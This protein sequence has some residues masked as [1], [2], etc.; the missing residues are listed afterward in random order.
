MLTAT[1]IVL[2]VL[3]LLLAVYLICLAPC[4]KRG[5]RFRPFEEVYIAHRGFFDNKG[6]APENSLAAFAAATERGYGIE[7]DVQ[8][9]RDGYLVVFHDGNLKRMCG[10]DREVEEC[11]YEELCQYT[12]ASSQKKIPLFSEA[13]AVIGG[14]VPLIVEIKN[15]PKWREA[16]EETAKLLDT[17]TGIYCLESFGPRIVAWYRKNRP[18][19]I[20]G[21]L[22]TNYFKDEPEMRF[23]HKLWLTNLLY[24]VKAKPD[25]I[26]YHHIHKNQF[27]YRLL[28]K[29]FRVKNVAWTIKNQ[30]QLEAAKDVFT[31]IIF[32]SFTPDEQ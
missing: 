3:V 1:I 11:T 16:S 6:P 20:R 13:L 7:L 23:W 19:V 27:S 28:R 32:D 8:L 30:E 14:K 22:S 21:Q 10:V 2:S 31:C 4:G 26:A 29:L 18:D 9:T 5:E 15:S 12:L 25:F 17:Y 24:N